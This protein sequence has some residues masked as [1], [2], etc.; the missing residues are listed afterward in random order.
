MSQPNE[1]RDGLYFGIGSAK[2]QRISDENDIDLG[3]VE[4]AFFRAAVGV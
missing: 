1:Q 2:G 4:E 3:K